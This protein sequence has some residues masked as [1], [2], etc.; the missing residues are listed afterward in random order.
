MAAVSYITKT[1]A[2]TLLA[3]PDI[4]EIEP[5]GLLRTHYVAKITG[6]T[7]QGVKLRTILFNLADMPPRIPK[8][9]K[10]T[11]AEKGLILKT[12][13]VEWDVDPTKM[14]RRGEFIKALLGR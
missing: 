2:K 8:E 6:L 1:L 10:L 4:T 11:K 9:L 5:A 14:P 12:Y 7:E 3:G 13:R